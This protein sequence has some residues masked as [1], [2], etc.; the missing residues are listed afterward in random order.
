MVLLVHYV[1][2]RPHFSEDTIVQFFF[3][4]P[5]TRIIQIKVSPRNT[6]VNPYSRF[7]S[8]T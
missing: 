8:S 5:I 1:P 4:D 7:S 2:F 3:L 6:H